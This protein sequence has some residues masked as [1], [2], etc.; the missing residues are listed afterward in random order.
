M[1]LPMSALFALFVV[2][3][4]HHDGGSDEVHSAD[5]PTAYLVAHFAIE[6]SGGEIESSD[7]ELAWNPSARVVSSPMQ[8]RTID[9]RV[10]WPDDGAGVWLAAQGFTRP[11]YDGDRSQLSPLD[12]LLLNTYSRSITDERLGTI[13]VQAIADN[14]SGG[15]RMRLTFSQ[16]VSPFEQ[17]KLAR[18]EQDVADQ[19]TARRE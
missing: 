19:R 12:G 9:M 2:G 5:T 11:D 16:P 10:S 15:S 18:A 17:L 8:W 3:C 4:G 1:R 6:K 14:E 13:V 7:G